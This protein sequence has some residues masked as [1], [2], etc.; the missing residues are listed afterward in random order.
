VPAAG[1]E[2][3]EDG[4][5][6]LREREEPAIGRRLLIA[7][8]MDKTAGCKTSAGDAGREPRLVD[9]G[10]E[11]G[12]LTPTGAL[13]RFAGIAYEDKKEVQTVAGG[14]H[15]AVRSAT[16]H[17]AEGG[18][19][20]EQDGGGMGLGVRSDGADGEPGVAVE[21][22]DG[23]P[24]QTGIAERRGRGGRRTELL[25]RLVVWLMV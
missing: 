17:V 11:A 15:H 2:R 13:A 19:K 4:G 25:L 22:G 18:Q 5:E 8:G 9:F 1:L 24:G 16:D 7:K 10:K 23:E 20:L 12:D 3:T 6:L 21:S 14:I